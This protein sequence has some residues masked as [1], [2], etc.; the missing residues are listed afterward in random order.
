VAGQGG[1]A[2][3]QPTLAALEQFTDDG[4]RIIPPDLAWDAAV[5]VEGQDRAGQNGLG[6]LAGQGTGVG[7]VGIAPGAD[8]DGY[9]AAAVGEI[10]VDVAEVALQ[11]LA[12]VVGQGDEGLAVV[13]AVAG[14]VAADLV[15]AAPV[16]VLVA[17]VLGAAGK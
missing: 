4:G 8:Q 14:D 9:Q 2:L 17:Q 7:G 10:D 15:V 16:G 13:L 6:A 1:V 5:E 12:G 3:V 11:A